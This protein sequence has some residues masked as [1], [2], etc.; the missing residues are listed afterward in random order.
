MPKSGETLSETSSCCR[1]AFNADPP[2]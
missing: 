1:G 2:D